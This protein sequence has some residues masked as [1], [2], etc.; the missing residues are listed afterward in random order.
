MKNDGD[1]AGFDCFVAHSYENAAF[2]LH[3]ALLEAARESPASP[4]LRHRQACVTF[5]EVGPALAQIASQL[6]SLAGRRVIILLPDGLSAALLH[7]EC[8]SQGATIVPLSPFS[9]A[10]HVQQVL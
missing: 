4:Y 9:P 5:S 6:P 8:F 7:L 1:A 2:D 10:I 3:E